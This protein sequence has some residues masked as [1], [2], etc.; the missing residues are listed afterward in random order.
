MAAQATMTIGSLR[1][2][3]FALIGGLVMITGAASLMRTQGEIAPVPAAQTVLPIV[4]ALVLASSV[5]IAFALRARLV[6]EAAKQKDVS[7]Q[8][9]RE[10]KVPQALGAATIISA[11][12]FEGPGL[13]GAVTVLLGGPWYC[14]AAPI[15]AIFAMVWLLPSRDRFEEALRSSG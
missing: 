13:L 7:L 6:T 12:L 8:L 4:V 14:L 9:L 2:I 15:L 5:A 3:L 1:I 10:D 11:A